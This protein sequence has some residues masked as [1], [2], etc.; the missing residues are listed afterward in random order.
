MSTPLAETLRTDLT[1][2][3]RARD[4]LRTGALRMALAALQVEAVAGDA[5]R[6]L[7]DDEVRQVLTR[8][9][10]K[11]REAQEAFAGAG[12]TDQAAQE[13]AEAAVL[14]AYLPAQLSDAE[15]RQLIADALVGLPTDGPRAMGPA[16]KAAQAAVAGRA[17]G[18][19]VSAEVKR[20]L[21]L[22]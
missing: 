14:E 21:G 7:S 9:V 8:E 10:R 11:R 1:A 3:M 12:R 4:T 16:M 15:L 6:V 22:S 2:A 20:A 5:V 17:D 18:S 13:Q 19:R